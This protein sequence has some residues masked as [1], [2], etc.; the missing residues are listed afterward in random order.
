[1]Q[2]QHPTTHRF[3]FSGKADQF[4]G[5]CFVNSI[6]TWLTLGIYGPW[7]KV[8]E[9]Q[10]LYGNT[11]LAGGSFQFTAD[12][13]KMLI[14]RLIAIAL[15]VVYMIAS[16]FDNTIAYLV[17]G[18]MVLGYL[19]LS[20]V[21]LVFAISFR[22]RFSQWRGVS[23]SF[24]RD[25]A[26]AYRIYLA[27]I[28]MLAL[29][30]SLLFLPS[31]S[32]WLEQQ[33]GIAANPT[34][35]IEQALAED[36]VTFGEDASDASQL[37]DSDSRDD[38]YFNPWFLIPAAAA[39]IALVALLPWFDF[40]HH[41]FVARNIRFGQCRCTF[42]NS[43]GQYYL[44]WGKWL[45]AT[46]CLAGTLVWGWSSLGIVALVTIAIIY[47]L[48]TWSYFRVNRYN[49]Q[50]SGMRFDGGH[51]CVAQLPLLGSLW[52]SLSNALA[53]TLSFGLLRAWARIRSTRFTL[54]HTQLQSIGSLDELIA[55]QQSQASAIGEEVADIFDLGLEVTG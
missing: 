47:W 14:S 34:A 7:A 6:L 1:M 42:I 50:L 39:W 12:P 13:R 40:I 25:F 26:G 17:L 41:R 49:L 45:L 8:R 23:F 29:A 19:L 52:L 30:S 11:E 3:T 15:F 32:H 5:I 37:E 16:A 48:V 24:Q 4:F 31:Q 35:V 55:G 18:L 51:R 53:V 9:W 22:L 10:Y 27:P 33:F 46:L 21:L 28:L 2:P 36:D 54:A 43:P 44:M 20:P 38:G